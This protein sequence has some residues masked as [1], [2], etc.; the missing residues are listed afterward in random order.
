MRL[1]IQA[2]S[3]SDSLQAADASEQVDL[4]MP[5][6]S[7]SFLPLQGTNA[8]AVEQLNNFETTNFMIPCHNVSII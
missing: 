1:R 5:T 8:I 3:Q 2:Q 4:A 6:I 7:L